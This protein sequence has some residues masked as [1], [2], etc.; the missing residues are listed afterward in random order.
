[1]T[2]RVL[3]LYELNLVGVF[4]P[5]RR[6]HLHHLTKSPNFLESSLVFDM[7]VVTEAPC[8]NMWSTLH[9]QDLAAGD[10]VIPQGTVRI[11]RF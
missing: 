8:E 7:S 1:M 4:A 2:S 11:G 3:L 6:L 10:A 9:H 5:T